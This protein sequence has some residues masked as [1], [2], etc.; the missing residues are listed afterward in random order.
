MR[1]K[2]SVVVPVYN[3]G[4]GIRNFLDRQLKPVLVKIKKNYDVELLIV[5]DGSEDNT[6]EMVRS[7]DSFKKQTKISQRLIAFSRNF[8]KEIAMTAGIKNATGDA[9]IIID[10]DGQHPVD[11]IPT[12]LEKW[13]SGAKIV[14]AVRTQNRT[15][16][17]LGSKLFYKIMHLLGN[18]ITEGAMDYRLIDKSVAEQFRELTEHDRITRGL[19]DWLGYPQEYIKVKINGRESGRGSY[20]KKKLRQLAIDSFVSMSAKPLIILGKLGAVIMMLSLVVGLFILI[21]QYIMGDP[22]QLDWSGAVAMC[23]FIS[24]LVGVVLVSQAI[25]SLYISQIHT[26]SQNRPL[27]LIDESKSFSVKNSRK[28]A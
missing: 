3:E 14:T 20:S 11:L 22:L 18:S 10:G 24:F 12:L 28:K 9:V 7:S 16:H 25:T 15:K 19:I 13:K 6:I 8:G 5:D 2:V 27:Y 4:S 17:R 1:K 26:E 23:V 21:Q